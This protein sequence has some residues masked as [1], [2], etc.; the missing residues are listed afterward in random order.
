MRRLLI[1]FYRGLMPVLKGVSCTTDIRSLTLRSPILTILSYITDITP[2]CLLA[3]I[4]T[5]S[6]LQGHIIKE[7]AHRYVSQRAYF[8][9]GISNRVST[10]VTIETCIMVAKQATGSL[11]ALHSSFTCRTMFCA[12]GRNQSKIHVGFENHRAL[13]RPVMEQRMLAFM[14]PRYHFS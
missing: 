10:S 5:S 14:R 9:V 6:V 1:R 7:F 11:S 2:M 3:M 12:K 13:S 8:G 4:S